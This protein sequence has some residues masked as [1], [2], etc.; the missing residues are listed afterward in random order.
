M[1]QTLFLFLI[2]WCA[3]CLAQT[4]TVGNYVVVQGALKGC[5]HWTWRILDIEQVKE[6]EPVKLL[7]IPN[8]NV[9]GLDGKSIRSALKAEIER[10]TGTEPTTLEVQVI[11]AIHLPRELTDGYMHS[12]RYLLDNQCPSD[13]E[14]FPAPRKA[15]STIEDLEEQLEKLRQLELSR[16]VAGRRL[17][18]QSFQRTQAV[19]PEFNPWQTDM[20]GS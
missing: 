14:N 18:N 2:V 13:P 20:R 6:G 7:G 10:R 3:T 11:E 5:E 8:I 12:L 1:K 4:A 17:Y 9:I 16:S 15:P 19:A